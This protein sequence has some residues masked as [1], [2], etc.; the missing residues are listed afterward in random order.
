MRAGLGIYLCLALD[1]LRRLSMRNVFY[2]YYHKE[3]QNETFS[4]VCDHGLFVSVV[5]RVWCRCGEWP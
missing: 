2:Y 4:V 5:G 3:S 1:D